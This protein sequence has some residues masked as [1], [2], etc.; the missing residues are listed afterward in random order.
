MG[1]LDKDHASSE[2]P[3]VK[4]EDLEARVVELER[5]SHFNLVERNS[6]R[7]KTPGM[8]SLGE[9]EEQ[10]IDSGIITVTKS[11]VRIETESGATTD[12]LDTI[13]GG[14]A[15]DLLVIRALDGAH[16]VVAK[17]ATGNMQLAGDFSLDT[18]LDTLI[19]IHG[20]NRWHELSRSDNQA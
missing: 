14:I 3:L 5:M 6:N 7:L 8:L 2:N 13:S 17:D 19:L 10:T 16:T 12:D 15:G 9:Y 4:I 1:I 11:F 18:I 20:Y